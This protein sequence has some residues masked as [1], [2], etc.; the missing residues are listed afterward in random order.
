MPSKSSSLSY[1]KKTVDIDTQLLNISQFLGMKMGAAICAP[2]NKL[3]VCKM[4]QTAKTT[5]T[6][7]RHIFQL[8]LTYGA[9]VCLV[10][11]VYI[12]RWTRYLCAYMCVYT[13]LK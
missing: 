11:C 12:R 1:Q 8:I 5:T 10:M 3:Y 4:Q 7:D 2:E 6:N 13:N 9:R